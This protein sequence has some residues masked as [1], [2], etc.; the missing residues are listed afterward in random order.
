MSVASA[1]SLGK[2]EYHQSGGHQRKKCNP[3]RM[4]SVACWVRGG[5]PRRGLDQA[6]RVI[7]EPG[8]SSTWQDENLNG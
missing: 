1:V 3:E 2:H 6:G 8:R 7:Y 5:K 4:D